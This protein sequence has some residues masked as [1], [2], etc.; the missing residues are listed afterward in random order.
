MGT[1]R[2]GEADGEHGEHDGEKDGEEGGE[3]DGEDVDGSGYAPG[4]VW[5]EIET[6]QKCHYGNARVEPEGAMETEPASY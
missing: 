5:H 4:V 3:G 6:V 1:E 2:Y